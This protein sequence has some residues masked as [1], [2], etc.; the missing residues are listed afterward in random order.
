MAQYSRQISDIHDYFNAYKNKCRQ[1]RNC[2]R[3]NARNRCNVDRP[4]IRRPILS[5]D[6]ISFTECRGKLGEYFEKTRKTHRPI[7]VTQNGKPTSVIV[8]IADWEPVMSEWE[9]EQK[10]AEQVLDD[11]RIS[12][13]Q[14][15]RDECHS[16]KE[17]FDMMQRGFGL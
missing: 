12:Q 15:A 3:T 1:P 9:N 7:I 11:L 14:F 16:T 8:S 17:V 2:P 4:G 10:I 6:V 5:E 13:E